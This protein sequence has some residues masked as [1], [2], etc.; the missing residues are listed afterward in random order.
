M[1]TSTYATLIVAVAE[2]REPEPEKLWSCDPPPP[3]EPLVVFEP[4]DA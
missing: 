2:E 4:S 3:V 1:M